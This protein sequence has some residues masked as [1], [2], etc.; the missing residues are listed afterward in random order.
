YA[1]Q[2]GPASECASHIRSGFSSRRYSLTLGSGASST[3]SALPA[4][5]GRKRPQPVNSPGWGVKAQTRHPSRARTF[6]PGTQGARK[7]VARNASSAA[8]SSSIN[9]ATLRTLVCRLHGAH[10]ELSDEFGRRRRAL[11]GCEVYLLRLHTRVPKD[12]RDPR[13]TQ[14]HPCRE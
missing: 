1:S 2:V 13:F 14:T 12:L 6:P 8:A 9:W 7:V 3:N 11:D 10:A 4:S 5:S